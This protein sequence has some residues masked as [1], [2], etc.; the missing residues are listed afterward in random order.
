MRSSHI[1]RDPETVNEQDQAL[2]EALAQGHDPVDP[3]LQDAG[4]PVTEENA[5][6]DDVWQSLNITSNTSVSFLI[7]K[8]KQADINERLH[9]EGGLALFFCAEQIGVLVSRR[10]MDTVRQGLGEFR[11]TTVSTSHFVKNKEN[12]L[13]KNKVIELS[14]PGQESRYVIAHRAVRSLEAQEMIRLSGAA[15]GLRMEREPVP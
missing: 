8:G 6:E 11:Q 4:L 2:P 12:L 1:E 13:K 10:R 7:K 15:L 9:T 5:H 3:S 14:D